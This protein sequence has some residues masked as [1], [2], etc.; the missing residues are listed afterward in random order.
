MSLGMYQASV[1]V[2]VRMLTTLSGVLDKAAA[3]V[4]A[5]KLDPAALLTARLFSDMFPLGR[6]VQEATKHVHWALDLLAGREM[7][8][9]A[10]TETG[11]AEL[12]QRVS[13]TID[14]AKSFKPA[15]IDGSEERAIALKFPSRTLE[16]KGQPFLLHFALPN[17]YFH[18][19]TAYGVLRHN[20]VDI[21]KRDFLGPG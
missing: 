13:K 12:K 3:H 9:V 15:E 2:F 7:P 1:P 20:G 8:S 5:K 17:F 11:L 14:F 16:M 18:V 10:N 19:T 4:E 6:Q 21:G